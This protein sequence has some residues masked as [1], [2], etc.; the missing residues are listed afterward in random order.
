MS[1]TI[2]RINLDAMSPG[3]ERFVKAHRYG[4]PGARPKA[5][6][7]ASLHADEIPGM[8]AAHHLINLLDDADAKGAIKGEVIVVP[9]ANPVGAGQVIN[10]T[11]AGRYDFR[12]GVNFNRRWPD[13]S[14]GL[15]A[16]VKGKLGKDAEANIA[17]V[18]QALG[19]IVEQIYAIG[20]NAKLRRELMRLAYDADIVLDLHCDDIALMHIYTTNVFWPRAQDLAAEVGAKAV[21]LCDDSGAASFDESFFLPWYRL[22]KEVGPDY[23]VPAPVLTS[24]IEFRGQ[25]DVYDDLATQDARGL[26][27][28]LQRR[29]LIAGDPGPVPELKAKVANLD[30]CE[31]LRTPKAGIVAYRKREGDL[32]KAGDVI[33]DI[34]DPLADDPKAARSEL[35]CQAE[36]PVL[37]IRAMKAVAAGDSVVMIIGDKALP[38]PTGL[39]LSD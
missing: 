13:L 37:S 16:K 19:E 39:L 29:G 8:L 36:G 35:R 7:Q 23:P 5:Y 11:F 17:I 9:V 28:F 15:A 6:L 4:T 1:K 2:Q 27:R 38:H 22:Q 31:I 24:T 30:A 12:S 26:F 21:L 34:V 14:A 18:R 25:A 10:T 33:A 20:E 3:T 32:V